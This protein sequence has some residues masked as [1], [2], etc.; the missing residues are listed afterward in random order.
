MFLGPWDQGGDWSDSGINGIYRWLNRIWE[1]MTTKYHEKEVLDFDSKNLSQISNQT[2][3]DI[4]NG[5]RNFRFNTSIATLW[6]I[7]IIFQKLKKMELFL[8]LIGWMLVKDY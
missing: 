6:N 1:M 5:M 8:I 7:V 4:L 2:T 3:K